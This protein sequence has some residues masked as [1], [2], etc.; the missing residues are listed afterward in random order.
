MGRPRKTSAPS[1]VQ[2]P[3]R[4]FAPPTLRPKS[5]RQMAL[6]LTD[7]G[8]GALEF[9]ARV[10]KGEIEGAK[11]RDRID[12]ARLLLERGF[13]KPVDLSLELDPGSPLATDLS[14]EALETLVRQLTL[15]PG[16][17][18]PGSGSVEGVQA[19]PSAVEQATSGP[20]DE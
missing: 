20:K 7:D 14:S 17:A 19:V 13:G 2:T 4:S 6:E 5:I 11:A 1:L 16:G 8:Y 18:Q 12:A 3:N 10:Y 9:L 15:I